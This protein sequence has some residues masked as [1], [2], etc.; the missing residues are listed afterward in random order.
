MAAPFHPRTPVPRV[1]AVIAFDD[2]SPFQIS[3]PCLVFGHDWRELGAH[4]FD[5]PVCALLSHS[6]PTSA[7]FSIHTDH[8]LA[9]LRHADVVIMPTW[10]ITQAPPAALLDALRAAHKR[11]ATVVGLCLGSFV[12]AAAGLLDG[13]R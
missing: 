13:R 2:I 9:A 6:F 8:G 5:V 11:G 10:R 7:G 1:I 4:R 3:V 12:L